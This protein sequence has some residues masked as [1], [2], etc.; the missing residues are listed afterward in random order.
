MVA[1]TRMADTGVVYFYA[2]LVRLGCSDLNFFNGEVFACFPSYGS[3][4]SVNSIR[5]WAPSRNLA[6]FAGNGLVREEVSK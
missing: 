3:L 1:H 4:E 6:Y 2:N 5:P